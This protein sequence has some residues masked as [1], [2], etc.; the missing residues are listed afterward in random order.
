MDN[1]SNT[2]ISDLLQ[3]DINMILNTDILSDT[4]YDI[5]SNTE[6]WFTHVDI[7]STVNRHQHDS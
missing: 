1:W 6:I 3:S 5:W 7:W 2:I 4:D